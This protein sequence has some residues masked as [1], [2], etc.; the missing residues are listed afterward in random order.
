MASGPDFA[1]KAVNAG[2]EGDLMP[3]IKIFASTPLK[4]S[5]AALHTKFLPIWNV[6]PEVLKVLVLPTFDQSVSKNEDLFV[7]IRAKARPT[8]TPE[9]V[10][11]TCRHKGNVLTSIGHTARIRVELYDESYLTSYFAGGS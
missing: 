10:A 6:P 1:P 11:E 3:L 8:R 5:A 9:V 4:A 2:S 7:S